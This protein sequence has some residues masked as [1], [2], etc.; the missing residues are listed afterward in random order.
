MTIRKIHKAAT[1]F[2][3]GRP[4]TARLILCDLVNATMG[5]KLLAALKSKHGHPSD[6]FSGD[7]GSTA[8]SF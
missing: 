7:S 2:L 5:F 3:N 4:E 8:S 1:M 6:D